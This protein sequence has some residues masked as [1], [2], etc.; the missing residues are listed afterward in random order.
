MGLGLS[1]GKLA[2][3]KD[4]GRQNGGRMP[5]ANALDQMIEIAYAA[6]S[7]YRDRDTVGDGPG[8]WQV[9]TLPGA[10]PIHRGQQDFAGAERNHLAGVFDGVDP[11]GIASAV[12]ENFP[13]IR[14]AAALHPLGVDRNHDAL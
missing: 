5:L 4:R 12:G 11:G 13:A 6:G 3:M 7:D 10:V 9:E 8:Q 2:K 14:V 1:Y